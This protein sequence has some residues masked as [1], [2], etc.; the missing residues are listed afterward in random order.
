MIMGI[1]FGICL[2]AVSFFLILILYVIQ[3]ESEDVVPSAFLGALVWTFIIAAIFCISEYCSPSIT[4]IDVYRGR[5][6]LEITYRDS[7]PI[8]SVVVWKDK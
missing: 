7:I 2:L 4:P 3:K 1:F 6:T 5:T 8:D